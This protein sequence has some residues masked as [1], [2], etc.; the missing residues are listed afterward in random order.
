MNA[1]YMTFV[2]VLRAQL[3]DQHI[4]SLQAMFEADDMHES[5]RNND[6]QVSY[7]LAFELSVDMCTQSALLRTDYLRTT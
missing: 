6:D 7:V 3:R 4:E 2:Y 5:K 1:F